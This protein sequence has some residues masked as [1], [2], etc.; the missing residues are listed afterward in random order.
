MPRSGRGC[1][2]ASLVARRI[3]ST[4]L[5]LISG[6]P[7]VRDWTLSMDRPGL[8][9]S[10]ACTTRGTNVSASRQ[11]L[12]LTRRRTEG[13]LRREGNVLGQWPHLDSKVEHFDDFQREY[14][15]GISCPSD[16][17]MWNVFIV[18]IH[19]NRLAIVLVFLSA[20]MTHL[21]HD[22]DRQGLGDCHRLNGMDTKSSHRYTDLQSAR[23]WI[24]LG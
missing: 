14:T 19:F 16:H 23:R 15:R 4:S 1:S 11:R 22:H 6:A 24:V 5:L 12:S 2:T 10:T 3:M 7:L 21:H 9:G 8:R 18:F 17:R 20:Y 13:R